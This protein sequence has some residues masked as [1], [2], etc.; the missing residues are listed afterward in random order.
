[1]DAGLDGAAT[2]LMLEGMMQLAVSLSPKGGNMFP[3]TSFLL[4]ESDLYL[5]ARQDRLIVVRQ[6]NF[7]A[8]EPEDMWWRPALLNVYRSMV[9]LDAN[10][11]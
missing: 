1:M 5:K 11:Q 2:K 4:K 9:G 3:L 6:T 7:A 8:T 10:V